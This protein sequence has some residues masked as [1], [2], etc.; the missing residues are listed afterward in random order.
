MLDYMSAVVKAF[1]QVF[2]PYSLKDLDDFEHMSLDEMHG[3]VNVS[4]TE[5]LRCFA[6]PHV[7]AI[8]Q[9]ISFSRRPAPTVFLL[10]SRKPISA[11]GDS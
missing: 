11:S 8:T 4:V 2:F 6:S 7:I 10:G 9:R 3:G 5:E 1:L